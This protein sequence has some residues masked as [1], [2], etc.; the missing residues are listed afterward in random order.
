MADATGA[1]RAGPAPDG[2]AS[3]AQ[4]ALLL[5]RRGLLGIRRNPDLLIFLTVQPI[6]FLLL[7]AY[8]FG[9]SIVVPDVAY[10]EYLVPGILVQAVALSANL[11]AVNLAA[12]RQRGML[13]RFRSLP[14]S[15]PAVLA[16]RTASDLLAIVLVVLVTTLAGLLVGWRIHTGSPRALAGYLLLFLFGYATTWIFALIGLSVR[17]VDAAQGAGFV[18]IFPVTFVSNAFVATDA[19]PPWLAPLADWNPI[20]SVALS[21]RDLWGNAPEGVVRG[22]GLPAEWPTPLAFLW[23][24]LLLGA[25]VPLALSRYGQPRALSPR[26]PSPRP[27]G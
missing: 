3:A 13:D 2:L 6:I 18:W 27:R 20:S 23:C 5:A 25:F 17:S 9:G 26:L 10:R 22:S 11:T 21:L 7:F 24:A 14:M 1:G 16:G 4:D 19:L 8:V 15:G 12:D